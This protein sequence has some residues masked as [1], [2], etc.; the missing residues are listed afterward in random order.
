MA[1]K[2]RSGEDGIKKPRV[3]IALV[4]VAWGWVIG[5]L[6]ATIVLQQNYGTP[7]AQILSPPP[8]QYLES[9]D[10]NPNTTSAVFSH[11]HVRW[12]C[13][14]LILFHAIFA[15]MISLTRFWEAFYA[16]T[17]PVYEEPVKKN[18][19]PQQDFDE[20]KEDL[21]DSPAPQPVKRRTVSSGL[22]FILDGFYW[23]HVGLMSALTFLFILVQS[24]GGFLLLFNTVIVSLI[25]Q[26]YLM[27][28]VMNIFAD[29]I[30]HFLKGFWFFFIM[31][32]IYWLM[33]T[34]VLAINR[35]SYPGTSSPYL[36]VWLGFLLAYIIAGMLIVWFGVLRPYMT[37]SKRISIEQIE[38]SRLYL[39]YLDTLFIWISILLV[40]LFVK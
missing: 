8:S 36:M 35:S 25:T 17:G 7:P 21:V 12:F 5:I 31:Q 6:I 1:R 22:P 24:D 11:V 15:T 38:M 16:H 20:E 19:L 9:G 4:V 14:G 39:V 33:W 2:S 28:P 30:E 37:S 13:W 40:F 27:L 34:I 32:V 10:L 3:L 18:L 23:I 26:A 29:T